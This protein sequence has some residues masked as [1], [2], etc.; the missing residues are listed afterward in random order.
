MVFKRAKKEGLELTKVGLVTG[1]GG[2]VV[3]GIP[4]GNV[5]GLTAFSRGFGPAGS[6]LGAKL[7]VESAKTLNPKRKG[8][9]NNGIF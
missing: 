4:G 9:G 3:A 1:F 7:V 5:A 6:I 2:S 8:R